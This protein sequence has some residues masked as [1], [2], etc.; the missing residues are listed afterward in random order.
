MTCIVG[1]EH[2]GSVFMGGDSA[3][4]SDRYQIDPGAQRKVFTSGPALFGVSGSW[5]LLQVLKYR[6]TVPDSEASACSDI[7]YLCTDFLDEL[8][9]CLRS[10]GLLRTESGIETMPGSTI[11]LGYRGRLYSIYEDLQITSTLNNY[12]AI[13]CGK[14]F[15]LGSLYDTRSDYLPR[16]RL[17]RAL[18]A[19]EHHSAGVLSPFNYETDEGEE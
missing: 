12:D 16:E 10:E 19:A 17:A 1:I 14:H 15:A 9:V 2:E 7:E 11:L 13:G 6:F 8:R 5:R 3:S 4:V 18:A